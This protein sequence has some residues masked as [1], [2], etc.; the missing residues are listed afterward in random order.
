MSKHISGPKIKQIFWH[1][2]FIFVKN[3]QKYLNIQIF[4]TTWC[5]PNCQAVSFARCW[6]NFQVVAFARRW[7]NFQVGASARCW[8]NCQV[9]A[10]ARCWPN[11]QVG[12]SAR[13]PSDGPNLWQ[14]LSKYK[15]ALQTGPGG[16]QKNKATKT[17]FILPQRIEPL[18]FPTEYSLYHSPHFS[19]TR[20]T[21]I[22]D[23]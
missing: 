18:S 2:F 11:W 10:S 5:W 17:S 9:V 19:P 12:A 6:P 8:P 4:P 15:S 22:R 1:F 23:H 13:P 20:C 3:S 21:V 7:P 16:G 14:L